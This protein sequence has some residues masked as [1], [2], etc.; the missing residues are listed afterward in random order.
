MIDANNMDRLKKCESLLDIFQMR[1]VEDVLWIDEEIFAVE[2]TH[3][4]QNKYQLVSL[5]DNTFQK[6][7]VVTKSVSQKYDGLR[8]K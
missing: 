7:A 8:V 4:F 3:N 5:I 2:V 6:R 1:R